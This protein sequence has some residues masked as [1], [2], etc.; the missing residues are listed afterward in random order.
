MVTEE[1][2][3]H[4]LVCRV[5]TEHLP[6][7]RPCAKWYPRSVSV[8]S[9]KHPRKQVRLLSTGEEMKPQRGEGTPTVTL[10]RRQV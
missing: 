2:C 5:L 10:P 6:G 4:L 7:A 1:R 9:L 3:F 8:G